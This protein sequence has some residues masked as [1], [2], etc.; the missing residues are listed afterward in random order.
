MT[1]Q[2]EMEHRK[3]LLERTL[4]ELNKDSRSTSE[5]YNRALLTLSSAFLGGSL[6]FTDSLVN[7]DTASDQWMLY[8]AWLFFALTILLTL[9][10]VVYNLRSYQRLRDA[11]VDYYLNGSKQAR[12]VSLKL[13]TVALRIVVGC[14]AMF[15]AGVLFLTVFVILNPLGE[16]YLAQERVERSIPPTTIH[17]S[18]QVSQLRIPALLPTPVPQQRAQE[19]PKN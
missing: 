19:A 6:A 1:D 9:A 18:V 4:D 5:S 13:Q 14:G 7:M 2:T 3:H 15:F 17:K 8:A 12:K 11:A 10:S 16:S